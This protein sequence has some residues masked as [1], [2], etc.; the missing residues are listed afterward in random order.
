MS[1]IEGIRQ[2]SKIIGHGYARTTIEEFHGPRCKYNKIYH[3]CLLH[4]LGENPY[5][6]SDGLKILRKDLRDGLLHE[7]A[8]LIGINH[9]H[10]YVT[11]H[12]S[13][14]YYQL[15]SVYLN[16]LPPIAAL[17]DWKSTYLSDA[18]LGMDNSNAWYASNIVMSYAVLFAHNTIRGQN[19]GCLPLIIDHLNASQDH[20]TGLWYG[21]NKASKINAMAATFHY[22]PLYSYLGIKPAHADKMFD[23]I[24]RLASLDGFFNLPAGYA[25]LDY[26]GISSLQFLISQVLTN[27]EREARIGP[28]LSIATALRTH[29]LCMQNS[30]G[31]FPEAGASQGVWIDIN[32]WVSH[33]L[34]NR[35]FWSAAWN[36]RFIQK[37]WTSPNRHIHANSVRACRAQISESNTFS[38]WFRYMTLACCEDVIERYGSLSHREAPPRRLILPGLGYF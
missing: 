17:E 9:E 12:L 29:L 26:D 38:T 3:L 13:A 25:C 18:L 10:E 22:L 15:A 16:D 35:C 37:S 31:G 24:A 20:A 32:Q 1:L 2:F 30:D 34:R 11:L 8:A 4:V 21:T 19:S 14:L 27:H 36:G 23:S 5:D 28:I 6:I 33:V 7:D